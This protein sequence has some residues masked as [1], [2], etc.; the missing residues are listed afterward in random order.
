MAWCVN[1]LCEFFMLVGGDWQSENLRNGRSG[2]RH[3][4]NC[5]VMQPAAR[6]YNLKISRARAFIISQITAKF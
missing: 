2:Q 1:R 4:L 3:Q 6:Q 5:M